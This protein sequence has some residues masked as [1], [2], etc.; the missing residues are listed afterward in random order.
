MRSIVFTGGVDKRV[1]VLPVARGLSFL[2][3][4]LIV[5]DDLNYLR[6]TDKDRLGNIKVLY[7]PNITNDTVSEFDDGVEYVNVVYDTLKF[8]PEVHDSLIV[9]RG[10]DRR[11]LPEEVKAVTDNIDKNGEVVTTSKEVVITFFV[12]RKE[13]KKTHYTDRGERDDLLGKADI[14]ELKPNDIKWLMLCQEMGE[15]VLTKNTALLTE[16]AKLTA[17]SVGMSLKEWEAVLNRV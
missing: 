13:L 15:I 10:K 3:E 16:V 11:L 7:T 8:I 4:T 6:G 2:G 5:T 14:L 1:L 9:C 17:D 12:D